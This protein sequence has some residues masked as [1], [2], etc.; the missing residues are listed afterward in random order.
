MK[1]NR[2]IQLF[3]LALAFTA[4][5][6]ESIDNFASED[7]GATT[8]EFDFDV[9]LNNVYANGA[10][11]K[12]GGDGAIP[13]DYNLVARMQIYM[14]DEQGTVLT[15]D[16]LPISEITEY[17]ESN[18]NAHQL[19]YLNVFDNVRLAL[20]EYYDIYTQFYYEPTD[21]S[22]DI[23]TYDSEKKTYVRNYG[24]RSL[25]DDAEDFYVGEPMSLYV[26]TSGEISSVDGGQA[27]PQSISAERIVTKMALYI[28]SIKEEGEDVL[29]DGAEISLIYSNFTV[30]T[31]NYFDN[32]VYLAEAGDAQEILSSYSGGVV[33][34][35]VFVP[36]QSSIILELSV[37]YNET[38]Y[39]LNTQ[40]TATSIVIDFPNYI[41]SVMESNNERDYNGFSLP[42]VGLD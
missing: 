3:V 25:G 36:S 21:A 6:K 22:G 16:G 1:L 15:S 38:A 18:G 17:V 32:E 12:A 41:Y 20:G 30:P 13:E 35:Y 9:A 8:Q 34:D 33:S 28:D 29:E 7:M 11:T 40:K 2:T 26:S 14:V 24:R 23:Y 27:D 39:Y 4:C 31:Y 5:D 19:S 42:V 10:T 37:E